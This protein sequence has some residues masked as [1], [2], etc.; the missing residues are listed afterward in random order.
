[1][2]KRYKKKIKK[3]NGRRRRLDAVLN[4]ILNADG[5]QNVKISSNEIFFFRKISCDRKANRSTIL[6]ESSP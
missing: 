6:L 3:Q 1:M 5:A 2:F 4:I